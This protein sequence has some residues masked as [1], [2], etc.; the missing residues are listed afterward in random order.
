MAGDSFADY[1]RRIRAGDARAAEELLRR[2]EPAIRLEVR[3]RLRDQRLRRLVDSLDICQSVLASFFLRMAAGQYRLEQPDQLV[4]LLV[5]MTRHKVAYHAR[6]E[7]AQARDNR[8]AE[9]L[10]GRAAEIAGAEPTPSRVVAGRELLQE[11][12]H[13]LSP[14]E[15]RMAD[16]RA[17]GHDWAYIA[18][19]FGGTPQARRMQLARALNRVLEQLGVEESHHE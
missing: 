11:L 17:Q 18:S 1:V 7:R 19:R 8:R 4:K 14:E 13:R 9:A 5:V 15:R 6:K 3:L 12:R 2:Y 16:W 10:D